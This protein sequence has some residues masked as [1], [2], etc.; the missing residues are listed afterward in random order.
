VAQQS[1]GGG[2]ARSIFP[3]PPK[4]P[5]PKYPNVTEPRVTPTTLFDA[6]GIE[7]FFAPFVSPCFPSPYMPQTAPVYSW[8]HT[9]T[10]WAV[11]RAMERAGCP[12]CLRDQLALQ[13]ALVSLLS[14]AVRLKTVFE[15]QGEIEAILA[16]ATEAARENSGGTAYVTL[17]EAAATATRRSLAS[18][19]RAHREYCVEIHLSVL[20]PLD[21]DADAG[22]RETI[23]FLHA[24]ID[25]A[26]TDETHT[27]ELQEQL[28]AARRHLAPAVHAAR[29]R[30]ARAYWAKFAENWID[31][32]IF[33]DS[34]WHSVESRLA[35]IDSA[36]WW[37]RFL[38]SLQNQFK[39]GQPTE[40]FLH[41]QMPN[42][43]YAAAQPGQRKVLS[44]VIDDWR[45]DG[46]ADYFG[47]MAP[48]HHSMLDRRAR[49]KAIEVEDWFD[50]HVPDYSSNPKVRLAAADALR[51]QLAAVDPQPLA[52]AQAPSS[53]FREHWNN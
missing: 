2:G 18:H 47:L 31:D 30:A 1:A 53:Y 32:A 37:R 43:R 22:R 19:A 46:G 14:A 20:E 25:E 17:R 26:K 44:G 11:I 39:R 15:R 16:T 9:L 49:N 36:W 7:H 3:Q 34:P 4:I 29:R 21:E 51:R 8:P 35:R 52:P 33:S 48:V 41:Q 38:P 42:L 50:H 23:L 6:N 5:P 24:L 27:R 12:E 28:A 10:D 45:E 13:A 40:C